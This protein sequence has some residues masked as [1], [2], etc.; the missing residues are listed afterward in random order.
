MVWMD[1]VFDMVKHTVFYQMYFLAQHHFLLNSAV[2][3]IL[4]CSIFANMQ[5]YTTLQ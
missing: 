2:L 1:M 4:G 3:T 5:L